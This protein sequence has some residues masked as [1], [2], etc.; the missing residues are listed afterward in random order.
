MNNTLFI[1][2]NRFDIY[3][4]IGTEYKVFRD[5]IIDV[6]ISFVPGE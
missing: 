2:G 4:D 1:I 6:Y 3:H 5:Y